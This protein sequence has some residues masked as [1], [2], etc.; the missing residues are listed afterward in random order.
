MTEGSR[1]H[2]ATIATHGFGRGSLSIPAAPARMEHSNLTHC[3]PSTEELLPSYK[4]AAGMCSNAQMAY[5]T[6][7]CRR[8]PGASVPK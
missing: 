7:V 3:T 6:A 5:Q 4:S 1:F 8:V 2:L